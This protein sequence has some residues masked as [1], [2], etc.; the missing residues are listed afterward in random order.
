MVEGGKTHKKYTNAHSES[1]VGT[2]SISAEMLSLMTGYSGDLRLFPSNGHIAFII[3]LF[4]FVGP[5]TGWNTINGLRSAISLTL[6]F[7]KPTRTTKVKMEIKEKA[8][9]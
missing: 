6:L 2:K 9:L 8:E 4:Q 5:V 7:I 1:Q 3:L